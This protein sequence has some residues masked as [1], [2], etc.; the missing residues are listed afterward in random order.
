MEPCAHHGSTPPCVDAIDRGGHRAGR[1]RLPR[2]EPRGGG[3]RSS[4]SRPPGS[5]SSSSTRFEARR[6]NEAWR[7]WVA[8]RRPF[9]TYKVAATLDGRVTVPGRALGDRRGVAA[10]R[11]RA[12]RRLGRGRRRDGHRA[13]R[14]AAPRRA[15]RRRSRGS[16][17][18]SPSA[19]GR[20]PTGRSSSCATG[21]SPDELAALAGEGVQSL[22]LEGGPTLATAFLAD[23]L[24]DKLLVF[25]APTLSG[26]GPALLGELPRADRAARRLG[27]STR[28]VGATTV[29]A[30][31]RTSTSR[32]RRRDARCA[33]ASVGAR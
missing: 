2:P 5:R 9:V 13:G 28:P 4:G 22:L 1:R 31:R 7:T 25:V 32:R 3:R 29:A 19:A 15:R 17:A 8:Q 26:A 11:P 30:S 18:A 10:A 6:Q 12:A 27:P 20:C 33:S 14:R 16:R 23:G 24:V 21:R